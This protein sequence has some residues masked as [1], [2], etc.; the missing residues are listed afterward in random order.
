MNW[1][2]KIP[3]QKGKKM[4]INKIFF[5]VMVLLLFLDI[6]IFFLVLSLKQNLTQKQI[7]RFEAM[8]SH[9]KQTTPLNIKTAKTSWEVSFRSDSVKLPGKIC[10]PKKVTLL[11]SSVSNDIF[12]PVFCNWLTESK[13]P[14]LTNK[15]LITSLGTAD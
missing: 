14:K 7:A 1:D 5:K 4:Q 8:R 12:F 6:T 9:S 11:K 13:Q 3:N 10:D 15:I 2:K